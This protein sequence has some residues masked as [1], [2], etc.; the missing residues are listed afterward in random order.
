MP[1][2]VTR[3]KN[4]FCTSIPGRTFCAERAP[5]MHVQNAFFDLVTWS[6]ICR[7]GI[8]CQQRNWSRELARALFGSVTY[9]LWWLRRGSWCSSQ[10]CRE[11]SWT[12]GSSLDKITCRSDNYL[13]DERLKNHWSAMIFNWYKVWPK[14]FSFHEANDSSSCVG[15]EPSRRN[16]YIDVK[17]VTVASLLLMSNLW[18]GTNV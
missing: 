18:Q 11:R 9:H 5:R 7:A 10:V 16:K 17:G 8:F 3:S 2:H 12:E 4:A 1:D 13:C 14:I 6:G 15:D